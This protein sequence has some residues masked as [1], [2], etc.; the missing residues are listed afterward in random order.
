MPLAV[1]PGPIRHEKDSMMVVSLFSDLP[2]IPDTKGFHSTSPLSCFCQI[3]TQYCILF[4]HEEGKVEEEEETHHTCADRSGSKVHQ[5]S[6]SNLVGIDLKE[7][8]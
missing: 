3:L 8:D 2:Q 7:V 6:Q 1:S 4:I 5:H